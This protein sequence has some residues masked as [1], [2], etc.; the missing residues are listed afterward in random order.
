MKRI[1]AICNLIAA[2]IFA[3]LFVLPLIFIHTAHPMDDSGDIGIIGGA[4]GPTAI[5]ISNT[6]SISGLV[7][8][9]LLIGL[10][11]WNANV[12][13]TTKGRQQSAGERTS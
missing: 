10:L 4:D 3:L 7:F 2:A 1:L 5:F 12:M 8:A 9:V 6:P 13:W 11:L